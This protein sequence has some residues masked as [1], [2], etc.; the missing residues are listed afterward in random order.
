MASKTKMT[1]TALVLVLASF[2]TSSYAQWNYQITP[3]LWASSI[4]GISSVAGRDVGFQAD[5]TDIVTFVDA[6]IA[7]RFEAK[8]DNW[9]YFL[10]GFFIKLSADT[11]RQVGALKVTNDQSIIEGGVSYALTDQFEILVG[12]RYEKIDQ[13]LTFAVLP[14]LNGGDSW[15]DGF[16]GAAWQPI[17][18]DKWTVRLRGDIGTGDSDSVW[19]FAAVGGYHFNKAWSIYANYRYLSTDFESDKF[20]WD[21]DQSGLGL[22]LGISW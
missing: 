3:Y 9:G 18:S 2:S 16:I 10:D 6:G 13:T 1:I 7:A 14:R 5:F 21:V 20:K 12:G 4:E 17:K 22:G 19:Q 11:D 15:L 8:S